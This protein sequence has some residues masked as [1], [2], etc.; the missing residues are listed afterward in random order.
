M[1]FYGID[2]RSCFEY[3]SVL[4]NPISDDVIDRVDT[5]SKFLSDKSDFE[6]SSMLTYEIQ[7]RKNLDIPLQEDASLSDTSSTDDGV[8]VVE[9]EP[10]PEVE[11]PEGVDLI[12]DDSSSSDYESFLQEVNV[13]EDGPDIGN[14]HVVADSDVESVS[15]DKEDMLSM[16]S[17]SDCD[18]FIYDFGEDVISSDD[19][20]SEIKEDD[21]P[22]LKDVTDEDEEHNTPDITDTRMNENKRPREDISIQEETRRYPKR[23]K[24]RKGL[25]MEA[26]RFANQHEQI[27]GTQSFQRKYTQ[28]YSM[29]QSKYVQAVGFL[30]TRVEKA[31]E[32]SFIDNTFKKVVG[33]CFAQQIPVSQ[34]FRKFGE[35]ALAAMIN[36]LKQLND[37]AVEDKPVV[38]PI[39]ADILTNDDKE[40]A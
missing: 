8:E 9:P 16:V 14:V 33:V 22:K 35:K 30:A 26:T 19:S 29:L 36:E 39:D 10:E 38:V 27:Y 23:T 7:D 25:A 15:Q 12:V 34:V 18:N 20:S 28:G 24:T 37:G 31:K 3:K 11:V 13:E 40:K 17:T 6:L 4:K 1:V 5:M 32:T 2:Y 21:P